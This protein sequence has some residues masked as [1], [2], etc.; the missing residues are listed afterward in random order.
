MTPNYMVIDSFKL[1]PKS[2]AVMSTQEAGM[3]LLRSSIQSL[4][5]PGR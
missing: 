3:S 4:V 2:S 1:S 5:L